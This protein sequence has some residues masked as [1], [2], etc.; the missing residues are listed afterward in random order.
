MLIKKSSYIFLLCLSVFITSPLKASGLPQLDV[1]T[2]SQQLFWLFLNFIFV[3]CF[4]NFV[5][6]PKFKKIKNSRKNRILTQVEESVKIKDEI[7]KIENKNQKLRLSI[8]KKEEQISNDILEKIKILT[9]NKNADLEQIKLKE[10]KA[11]EKR[12]EEQRYASSIKLEENSIA[13]TKLLLNKLGLENNFKDNIII[14][15]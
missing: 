15:K 2:Y 13:I 14:K 5:I 1:S 11:F 8:I 6:I 9:Q 4:L 3:Y 12:L 7:E 10:Q